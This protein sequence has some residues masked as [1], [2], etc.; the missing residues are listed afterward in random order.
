MSPI[1]IWVFVLCKMRDMRECLVG[2]KEQEGKDDSNII[3]Y[4]YRKF[5]WDIIACRLK[6]NDIRNTT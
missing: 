2:G 5:V 4:V 3:N 1:S 6:I